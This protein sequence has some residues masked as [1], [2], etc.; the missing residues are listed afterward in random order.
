MCPRHPRYS[1]S[2]RL[3]AAPNRKLSCCTSARRS[4]AQVHGATHPRLREHRTGGVEDVV[5]IQGSHGSTKYRWWPLRAVGAGGAIAPFE[6]L[7]ERQSVRLGCHRW[8]TAHIEV[9]RL[10]PAATS[11]T[12]RRRQHREPVHDPGWGFGAC[13]CRSSVIACEHQRSWG[14]DPMQRG[15]ADGIGP[16]LCGLI[17]LSSGWCRRP[18]SRPAAGKGLARGR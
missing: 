15:P 9:V 2:G 5:E 16:V 17:G 13:G 4:I 10:R 11:A 14:L 12:A 7:Q 3:P 1:G 8:E 6:R 18:S